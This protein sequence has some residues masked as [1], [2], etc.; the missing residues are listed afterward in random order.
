[1]PCGPCEGWACCGASRRPKASGNIANA[2]RPST[3][4]A[5]CQPQPPISQFCTGTIRN[6]PKEPAAAVTPI[7]QEIL[8]GST[9]RA[10]TPYTTA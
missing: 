5:F 9:L 10:I 2:A 3:K 1:M 8:A 6:C 7:A 4:S